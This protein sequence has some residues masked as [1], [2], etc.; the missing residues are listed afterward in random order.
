M[1]TS[2][3]LDVIDRGKKIILIGLAV[4]CATLF[5]FLFVTINV[6]LRARYQLSDKPDGS[7][8]AGGL[9]YTTM[10]LFVRSIYRAIEYGSGK[11]SY[12][13]TNEW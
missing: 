13:T 7:K 3:S 10:S 1:L 12:I 5:L 2:T 9:Y 11:G 6:H 4:Q 8:L